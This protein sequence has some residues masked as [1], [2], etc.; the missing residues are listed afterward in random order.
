MNS[1]EQVFAS[2][3]LVYLTA[4]DQNIYADVAMQAIKN[5]CQLILLPDQLKDSFDLEN[6]YDDGVVSIQVRKDKTKLLDDF[7]LAMFTSGSTEDPKIYAF[8]S[9][10]L[11]QTLS[12][13]KKIYGVTD[14]SV[15]ITPMPTSYN[16]SFIAFI[17]LH[18]IFSVS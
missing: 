1:I 7:V 13:Y 2:N 18:F 10:K 4:T 15:I 3:K 11:E 6:V 17:L 14:K 8:N 9:E 5:G 16:F 12:W